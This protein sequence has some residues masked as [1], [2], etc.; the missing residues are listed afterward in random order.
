ML[1]GGLWPL[2]WRL[3]SGRNRLNFSFASTSPAA[4]GARRCPRTAPAL[5]RVPE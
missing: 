2:A 1:A 5:R 4:G 3:P